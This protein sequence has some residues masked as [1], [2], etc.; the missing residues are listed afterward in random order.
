MGRINFCAS[1]LLPN[2]PLWKLFAYI[3]LGIRLAL[4][5]HTLGGNSSTPGPCPSVT[6]SSP[7][8]Y[9]QLLSQPMP[10]AAER[11]ATKATRPHAPSR[12]VSKPQRRKNANGKPHFTRVGTMRKTNISATRIRLPA[13]ACGKTIAEESACGKGVKCRGGGAFLD[14]RIGIA[15]APKTTRTQPT[16][17]PRQMTS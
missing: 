4:Y 9:S 11:S 3:P 15:E 16:E 6:L 10:N 8:L 17:I 12:K 2:L 14:G 13:S 5:V 7:S 1:S